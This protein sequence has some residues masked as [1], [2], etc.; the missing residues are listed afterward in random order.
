MTIRDIK[1]VSVLKQPFIV[2]KYQEKYGNRSVR[3]SLLRTRYINHL[4]P[5]DPCMGRIAPLTYRI[6]ISY[7]YSTNIHTEYFK[8]AA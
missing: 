2:C 5:N 3:T 4:M 1:P 6:C 8:H 7:I